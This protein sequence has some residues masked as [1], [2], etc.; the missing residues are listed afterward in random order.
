MDEKANLDSA[1]LGKMDEIGS[2]IK[3]VQETNDRLTKQYDGLDLE[4]VKNNSAEA[5]KKFENLQKEMV[6]Q[7]EQLKTLELELSR[8]KTGGAGKSADSELYQKSLVHYMRRGVPIDPELV[9]TVYQE[10]AKQRFCNAEP[11]ALNYHAKDLVEG[12]G[13]AG[14]YFVAPE[15]SDQIIKRI[16]ETSPLRQV[17]QTLT[18]SSNTLKVP[19]DDTQSESGWIGEIDSLDITKTAEI[20]EVEFPIHKVYARP[21]LTQ[22]LLDD[23]GFNVDAWHS[24]KVASEMARQENTAFV[25]GNGAKKPRGFLTY[26]DRQNPDI[27]E[28][29]AVQ[30]YVSTG[31]SGVLDN[32][33]DFIIMQNRLFEQY[34][35]TAAWG[36][37]RQ[38]FS[39][40]MRLKDEQGQYLLDPRIL[41]S[42]SSKVLL[43]SPVV[44]MA[45]MPLV[46]ANA[47]SVVY[48]SWREFYYI[49]DRLGM[50][51]IRDAITAPT[52]IKITTTKRVGAGVGNFD[53]GIIMKV[54][55]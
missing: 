5:A 26:P 49:V 27:Y 45:D 38:T 41:Q 50:R 6:L 52:Y 7:S 12:S 33:D 8:N 53:A 39:E 13:P 21:Q 31:S 4:N 28:R 48:A 19:L 20:A 16:F 14:G 25:V 23:S 2:Q 3:S 24:E 15:Y 32:G 18:T 17:C 54:K 1:I 29:G 42:G 44:F 35:R 11:D 51:I 43:G 34:Q 46:A 36:L 40:V 10:C 9:K 22:D 55:A 30:Q 47:L 37:H